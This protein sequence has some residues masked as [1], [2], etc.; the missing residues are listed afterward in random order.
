MHESYRTE[1]DGPVSCR[2][3][4][5]G[6]GRLLWRQPSPGRREGGCS[7]GKSGRRF[8][9][10]DYLPERVRF[11]LLYSFTVF[12]VYFLKEVPK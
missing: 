8:L 11:L 3:D 9:N 1:T 7:I 4:G 2:G 5:P 10:S 12:P 6:P